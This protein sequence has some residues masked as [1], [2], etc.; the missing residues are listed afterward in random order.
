METEILIIVP[1]QYHSSIADHLSENF[2][3]VSHPRARI[4]LRRTTEGEKDE[5]EKESE[6]S[7][8]HK[9]GEREGTARILRRFKGYI[10]VSLSFANLN[11][12]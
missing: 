10:R 4:E 11:G 12:S 2:S 6:S 5:D 1:P 9:A 7:G 8:T 3:L